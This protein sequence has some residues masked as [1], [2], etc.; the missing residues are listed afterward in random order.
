MRYAICNVEATRDRIVKRVS[1]CRYNIRTILRSKDLDDV[2]VE[3]QRGVEVG[4]VIGH[5]GDDVVYI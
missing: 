3:E 4:G 2:V 5:N 1:R